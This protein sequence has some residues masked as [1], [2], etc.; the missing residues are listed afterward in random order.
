MKLKYRIKMWLYRKELQRKDRKMR[1]ITKWHYERWLVSVLVGEVKT[2]TFV[3]PDNRDIFE[4]VLKDAGVNYTCEEMRKR[5][6][7]H[8]EIRYEIYPEHLKRN[9]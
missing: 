6:P 4:E 5:D 7:T 1:N 8:K 2:W 3:H 9:E